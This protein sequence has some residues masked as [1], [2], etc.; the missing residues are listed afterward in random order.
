MASSS[1]HLSVAVSATTSGS[2]PAVPRIRR[3]LASR[4]AKYGAASATCSSCSLSVRPSMG[5]CSVVGWL[6]FGR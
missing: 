2:P 1:Q 3:K 4:L 5:T 6:S